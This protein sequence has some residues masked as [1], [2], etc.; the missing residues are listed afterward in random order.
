MRNEA[1]WGLIHGVR[2]KEL[3]LWAQ[4]APMALLGCGSGLWHRDKDTSAGLPSSPCNRAADAW[5]VGTSLFPALASQFNAHN[6]QGAKG[7]M[8]EVALL[9]QECSHPS[10]QGSNRT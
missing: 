1:L 10:G 8:Q 9:S 2:Q 6:F 3:D 5:K 7:C 4:G